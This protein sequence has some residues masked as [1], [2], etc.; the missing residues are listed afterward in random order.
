MEAAALILPLCLVYSFVCLSAF[1]S[2]RATPLETAGFWRLVWTH[3]TAAI[4]ASA[5]WIGVARVLAIALSGVS[6]F[7]GLER[8]V[9]RQYP[10]LLASGI[11]LYL[12]SVALHYVLL[13]NEAAHQA[14]KGEVEARVLARESELKALK[15]Q[16]NPHFVFNCLNSISALTTSD[17]VKARE[18]CISLAEFLRKTLG[19]GERSQIT[20]REELELT[21]AYLSVEQI[22]FG[23]RLRVE[24]QTDP[25]AL[26]CSLPPLLLQPLVENAVRHGI[27]TLTEGG[28]IRVLVGTESMQSISIQVANNFD[29]EAPRRRGAGIGLKNVRRRLDASYHSRARFDVRTDGDQF[30]VQLEIPAER[31][32]TSP[33]AAQSA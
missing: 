18:M 16:V 5:L 7:S 21:H 24:E 13:A 22:R 15:A 6:S 4:L 23:T 33:A 19:L 8:Q 28:W 32:A 9:N 30:L 25:E 14:E 11:F 1:Y 31:A 3:L 2:C 10:L 26:N 20:L 29:P 27:A 17:P 12:L